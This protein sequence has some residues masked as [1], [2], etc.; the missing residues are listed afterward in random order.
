MV[1]ATRLS[2]H[3]FSYRR[4]ETPFD[5]GAG[6]KNSIAIVEV[7]ELPDLAKWR[8]INVRDP[9]LTGQLPKEIRESFLGNLE[10]F[11]FLSRGLVLAVKGVEFDNANGLLTLIL[12]NPKLHG[13]LDGG[14]NYEIIKRNR[15][16]IR[17][18]GEK[19]YVKVEFIEGFDSDGLVDLVQARN[20]SKQVRDESLMNLADGFKKIQDVLGNK[21]YFNK[22]A[23]SEFELGE[24]GEPKPISI[25]E[26]ISLLMT[27][28]KKNFNASTHPINAYRS[29]AAC[30]KHF[31]DNTEAFKKIYPLTP[32]ILLLWDAIHMKLPDLYNEARKQSGVAGG[33][34]GSLTGVTTL[35]NEN[36]IELDFSG[37]KSTYLIPTGLKYPVLGAFRAML[38]DNGKRYVWG[39]GVDPF[40][41]LEGEL[42]ST[43]ARTIGEFALDA[44]NPSKTGKSQLVWQSCFQ[45][46]ELAY[47]R[48]RSK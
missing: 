46:A 43:L 30:L 25:R 47:L 8:E 9:K 21:P 15:G 2:F 19:Q 38:E 18:K 24:D 10:T 35:K 45:S 41:M 36:T 37:E 26:I 34:F 29:K 16:S 39:K 44:K 27:M 7:S 23:F 3:V 42:G 17:D 11:L 31:D 5:K 13:L 32:D 28:D 33:R 20:S 14:H 40:S 6:Y 48:L 4:L 12:D 1:R 22:I